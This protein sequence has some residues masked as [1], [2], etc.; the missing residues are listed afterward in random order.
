MKSK[1]LKIDGL[2]T[3]EIT[4]RK[5]AKNIVLR[6]YGTELIKVSLPYWTSYRAAI[7]FVRKSTSWINKRFAENRSKSSQLSLFDV[8]KK[9]NLKSHEYRFQSILV[10]STNVRIKDGVI[11]INYPESKNIYD[12]EVQ[13]AV[14]RG[15]F[16]ALRKEAKEY[17]PEKL[18]GLAR[19]FGFKYKK[20][21]LKNAISQWGS[22]SHRNNINLSIHL[23]KLPDDLIEY[24][25]V[26]ELVHTK[27]KNHRAGFYE[28]LGSIYKNYKVYEKRLKNYERPEG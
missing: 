6:V 4:R 27:E 25:M 1:V 9:F 10:E 21:Y 20:L 15:Y 17:F 12:G 24:V 5:R 14:K 28:K 11:E 3:V 8:S 23:M 18:N 16:Q 7:N 2:G 26:H 22:C 13:N 19:K